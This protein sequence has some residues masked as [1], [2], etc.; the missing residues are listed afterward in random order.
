MAFIA[1]RIRPLAM[2]R[3]AASMKIYDS[4]L[5][6]PARRDLTDPRSTA[7]ANTQQQ[8]PRPMLNDR[9]STR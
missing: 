3:K 5:Q 9:R 6:A 8:A 4:R 1:L 7:P 2:A